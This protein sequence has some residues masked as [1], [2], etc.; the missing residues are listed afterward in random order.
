MAD[1]QQCPACRK[2]GP[3]HLVS[4][5]TDSFRYYGCPRCG[6]LFGVH[7]DHPRVF[8]HITPVPSKPETSSVK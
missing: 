1:V 8:V 5:S 2:S 3:F 4:E 7:K 6:H